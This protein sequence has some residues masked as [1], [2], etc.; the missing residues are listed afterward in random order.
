MADVIHKKDKGSSIMVVVSPLKSLME[1]Q[2]RALNKLNIPAV[3]VTDTHDDCL[4]QKIIN[5]EF[6][7]IYGSPECFLSSK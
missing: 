3:C 2:V 1:D 6:T 7:H 5:G 4:I